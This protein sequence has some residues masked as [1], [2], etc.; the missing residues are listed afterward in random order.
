VGISGLK[1][2]SVNAAG[3][4]QLMQAGNQTYNMGAQ[5]AER[6]RIDINRQTEARARFALD[7]RQ[8]KTDERAAFDQA[9]TKW[10]NQTQ[11]KN[12]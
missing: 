4:L 9:V 3:Y 12:Y 11:G 5:L 10:K 1:D 6:L 8:E 2:A 7:E